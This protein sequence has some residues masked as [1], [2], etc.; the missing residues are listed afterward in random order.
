MLPNTKHTPTALSQRARNQEI[1]SFVC[2]PE[3]TGMTQR[4]LNSRVFLAALLAMATGIYLFY[5]NPFPGEQIF[6]RVISTRAPCAFLS[7]KYL[8]TMFLFTTPYMVY[9]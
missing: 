9:A 1:A 6:L 8:Y 2:G 7:F 4:I 3:R 5:T